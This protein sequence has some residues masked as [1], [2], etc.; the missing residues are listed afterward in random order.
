MSES[1]LLFQ[2]ILEKL[3][4]LQATVDA[5]ASASGKRR[6]EPGWLSIQDAARLAGLSVPA[7]QTR[8]RRQRENPSGFPLR[9]RHGAVNATDWRA[10]LD[11]CAKRRAGRG[12]Q[13]R[14]ALERI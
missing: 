8:I 10:Y 12:E 7:T 11:A 14:A 1:S 4:S 2:A 3:E 13:V 6:I 5:L 9:V